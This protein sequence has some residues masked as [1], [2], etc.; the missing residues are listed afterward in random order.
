MSA[1]SG[2]LRKVLLGIGATVLIALMV[3]AAFSLGVYVGHG[4]LLVG[5]LGNFGAQ[6]APDQRPP[7]APSGPAAD[8]PTAR[9]ALVGRIGGVTNEG[10]L[11]RTQ[12]GP[13]LV[14]VDEDT[15]VRDRQGRELALGDLRR[16]TDVA[17]FGRFSEDGRTLS[18]ETVVLVPPPQPQ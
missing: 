17:V 14:Q 10:L 4:R 8:L 1:D 6:P 12:R 13:R 18:A 15:R 2:A 5:T 3:L 9:P 11:V 16:G 7:Q